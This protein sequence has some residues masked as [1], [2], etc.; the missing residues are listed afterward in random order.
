MAAGHRFAYGLPASLL[1]LRTSDFK[2]V[3]IPDFIDARETFFIQKRLNELSLRTVYIADAM[4]HR[5][6]YR[7][8]KPEWEG[9]NT[10]LACGTQVSEVTFA[11]KVMVLMSL[12]SRRTKNM[13]YVPVSL[14]KFMRGF[15]NPKRFQR[16][17]RK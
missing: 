12:N 15:A 16:L 14:I 3:R 8:M 9:A 2:G 4:I 11:F 1:A 13:I 5:S 7:R 10:R 17:E 6:E